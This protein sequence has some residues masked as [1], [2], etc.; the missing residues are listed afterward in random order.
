MQF[1]N[2]ILYIIL[3]IFYSILLVICKFK[4]LFGKYFFRFFF[5]FFIFPGRFPN[6]MNHGDLQSANLFCMQGRNWVGTWYKMQYCYCKDKNQKKSLISSGHTP[7]CI[8]TRLGKTKFGSLIR[9][10]CQIQNFCCEYLSLQ[11]FCET[12]S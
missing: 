11:S 2:V 8:P 5:L 12:Q 1:Q 9:S 10:F 4:I 3:D 6:A 7:L